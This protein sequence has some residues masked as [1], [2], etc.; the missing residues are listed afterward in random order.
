[1]INIA[2]QS[3]SESA[4]VLMAAIKSGDEKQIK[5]A[6]N[7]FQ[8]AIAAKVTKQF[9]GLNEKSDKQ[10]LAQRGIRQLTSKEQKFYEKW[11]ESAK[12]SNPKQAFTDL[13]TDADGMPE[14]I[15]E[16]VYRDL[17]KEHPLLSKVNFQTVGYLTEWLLNDHNVNNYAWGEITS[18]ITAQIESGF[19]K[20]KVN[21]GKLSAFVLI[22]L[23]M[24]ELGPKF[25]DAYVRT[26][27]K[28]SMAVGLE[29]G[30]VDG[31]GVKGEMIGLNRNISDGVSID[32]NN[33][34]P[35]KET[36]KVKDFTPQTYG[37]L[38]AKVVKTEKGNYRKY[39]DLTMI[40]HPIDYLTKIMPATTVQNLNGTYTN[41]IFP[42][43]TAVCTS[44]AVDEGKA[45]LFIPSDYFI[46]VGN[47]K[48]GVITY[49]D[50]YKFLEDLRAYK[51]KVFAT[52]EAYDNTVAIV[53]DIS[54][55]DPA[56]ITVLNKSVTTPTK[57]EENS[58]QEQE[59]GQE[60][61]A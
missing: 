21:L 54:E 60:P 58:S 3:A 27:L 11:I 1:M 33:G 47:A 61:E 8:D 37:P 29:H 44:E 50:D 20:V 9:E 15:I 49:S 17:T 32:S 30:M 51:V 53:L 23:D 28:E 40:C 19:R 42:V 24:L 31:K 16:D 22:A 43:P 26:L 56:Y 57:V 2:K 38:V 36:I 41:N 13:L 6:M 35:L 34:Y 39:D 18:E 45:I 7:T 10:I 4:S 46:G 14:T 5:E 48:E 55:L 25:L 12:A 59:S 52:G